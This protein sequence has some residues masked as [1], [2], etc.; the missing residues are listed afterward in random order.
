MKEKI[1][2]IDWMEEARKTAE[3]TEPD[4]KPTRKE[5]VFWAALQQAI[6]EINRLKRFEVFVLHIEGHL[7]AMGLDEPVIC[8]ICGKTVNQIWVEVTNDDSIK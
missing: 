7:K 2:T 6:F 1:K 4:P 3:E 8:K 5:V